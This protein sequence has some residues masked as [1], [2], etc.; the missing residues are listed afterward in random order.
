MDTHCLPAPLRPRGESAGR[1]RG[2]QNDKRQKRNCESA[3]KEEVLG[4]D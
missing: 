1:D 3:D 4:A 2:R